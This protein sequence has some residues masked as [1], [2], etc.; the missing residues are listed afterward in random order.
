[1]VGM[2]TVSELPHLP[3]PE[4]PVGCMVLHAPSGARYRNIGNAWFRLLDEYGREE[5]LVP[6]LSTSVI[7]P[8]ASNPLPVHL[9]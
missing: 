7:K 3:S 5:V 9:L 2:Q 1:M 8:A 6:C 4:A